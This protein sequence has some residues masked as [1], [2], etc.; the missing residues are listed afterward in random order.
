MSAD[1]P[2]TRVKI[3][4]ASGSVLKDK[5]KKTI[6]ILNMLNKGQM[7]ADTGISQKP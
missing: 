3:F 2:I 6:L 5:R 7:F 1:T 4:V